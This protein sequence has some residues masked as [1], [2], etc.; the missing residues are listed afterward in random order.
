MRSLP[1]KKKSRCC[2]KQD[3]RVKEDET[4]RGRKEEDVQMRKLGDRESEGK[5]R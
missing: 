1:M 2:T 3:F 5:S 4:K